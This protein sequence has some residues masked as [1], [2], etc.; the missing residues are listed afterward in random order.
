M[1]FINT[2]REVTSVPITACCIPDSRET[3]IAIKDAGADRVVINYEICTEELFEKYRGKLRENS[4]YSWEKVNRSVSEALEVFGA[5]KVGTHLIIGLGET[6]EEALRFIQ[7][8]ID[9]KIDVSLFAFRP[10]PNT[11]LENHEQ[12]SYVDYH[13]VQAGRYLILKKKSR[14]EDMEFDSSG[15]ITHFGVDDEILQAAINSGN[16]FENFGGCPYCNRINYD[17]DVNER[18][19]SYPRKLRPSEIETIRTELLGK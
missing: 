11:D 17:N 6:Q 3:L 4:P 10:V 8:L 19:Y 16:P 13:R 5:G 7:E 9:N 12:I 15:Q 2:I 1:E 14:F 18:C